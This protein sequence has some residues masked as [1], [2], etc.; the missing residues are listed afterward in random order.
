[1]RGKI[2]LQAVSLG[3]LLKHMYILGPS[4]TKCGLFFFV[5]FDTSGSNVLIETE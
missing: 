2:C 4:I 5:A 1:M 3:N